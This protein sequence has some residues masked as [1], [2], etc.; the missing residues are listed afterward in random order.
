[1]RLPLAGLGDGGLTISLEGGLDELDESFFSRAFS[2]SSQG[3]R[4]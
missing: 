4:I 3:Y 2:A 1:L